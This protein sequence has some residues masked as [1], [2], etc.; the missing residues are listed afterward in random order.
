MAKSALPGQHRGENLGNEGGVMLAVAVDL[1]QK[2][3][4]LGQR[5]FVAGLDGNTV[6]HVEWQRHHHGS[7][8][9]GGL[10]RLVP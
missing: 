2:L 4:A 9:T 7:G 3:V 6:A 8:R 1:H 10:G 5:E